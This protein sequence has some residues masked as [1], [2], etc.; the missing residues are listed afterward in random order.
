MGNLTKKKTILCNKKTY[1]KENKVEK[2]KGY[3]A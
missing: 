1:N 3:K 2:T